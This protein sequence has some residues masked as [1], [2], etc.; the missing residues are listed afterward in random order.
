MQLSLEI[1]NA[2]LKA[3]LDGVGPSPILKL[4]AGE[5]PASCD[6]YD[7]QKCLATLYL[8]DN[9]LVP[10]GEG[11]LNQYGAWE[12]KADQ[13]GRASHYRILDS[14]GAACHMQGTASGPEGEGEMKLDNPDLAAGQR[15]AVLSFTIVAGNP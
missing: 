7:A 11:S 2:R 1:R 4:Y 12:A 10:D 15:V 13:A 3:T 6:I 8:P 5:M 9:W 14:Y